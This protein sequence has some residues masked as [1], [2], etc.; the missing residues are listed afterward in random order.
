MTL[1]EKGVPGEL[2]DYHFQNKEVNDV[3]MLEAKNQENKPLYI[4]WIKDL[5][6]LKKIMV[7]WMTIDELEGAKTIRYYT[8]SSCTK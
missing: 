5:Y 4:F 7:L 8:Y 2:I 3:D 6:H 1:L